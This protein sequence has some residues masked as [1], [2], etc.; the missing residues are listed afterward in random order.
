MCNLTLSLHPERRKRPLEIHWRV[1]EEKRSFFR[2]FCSFGRSLPISSKEIPVPLKE[3]LLWIQALKIATDFNDILRL[4]KVPCFGNLKPGHCR[5]RSFIISFWW[6]APPVFFVGA[7]FGNRE[8]WLR[9]YF[10]LLH[11]SVCNYKLETYAFYSFKALRDVTC[12]KQTFSKLV[13]T[14]YKSDSRY[15]L[16][17]C[18]PYL[19][20]LLQRKITILIYWHW[21]SFVIIPSPRGQRKA[22]YKK[23]LLS[24]SGIGEV[25][26]SF[27]SLIVG[28]NEGRYR[29]LQNSSL[30]TVGFNHVR[31]FQRSLYSKGCQAHL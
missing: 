14:I 25:L 15:L 16:Q 9:S 2:Y 20:S 23:S 29:S 24:R 10:S 26:V 27:V 21:N 19:S 28:S 13:L 8:D 1:Q 18:K 30:T 4:T 22:P 5:S 17:R 11:T 12:Q 31:N 3:N 6:W 7:I